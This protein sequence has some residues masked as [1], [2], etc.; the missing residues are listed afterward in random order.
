[1]ASF[2]FGKIAEQPAHT[3]VMGPLGRLD[4]EALGL[5][6]HRADFLADGVERQVL[7]EP[8]RVA[9]QKSLHVLA[10]YRRKIGAKALLIDLQQHV[11]VALFLFRHFHEQLGRI[12]VAL[13]QIFR[14]RHVD[15]AVFFFSRD[16]DSQYL[17]LAQIGEILHARILASILEGF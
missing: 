8:D 9:P 15:A 5:E 13:R 1:M 16:R 11:P 10:T 7:G 4:V 17:A 6:F 12:G 3:D 14:E 2:S